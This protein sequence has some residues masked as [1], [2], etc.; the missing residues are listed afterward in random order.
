MNFAK[1]RTPLS[2]GELY[3]ILDR[4]FRLRQSRECSSCYILLPFRVDQPD[5][6]KANWEVILPP[7]C[8]HGCTEVLEEI[9]EEY[10]QLHELAADSDR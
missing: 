8:G 3:V 9:V 4:E 5:S 10:S 7:S 1:K 2:A 6:A